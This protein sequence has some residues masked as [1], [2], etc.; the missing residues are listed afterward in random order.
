M[1]L[2]PESPPLPMPLSL[3]AIYDIV[4]VPLLKN[5]F[6]F[7]GLSIALMLLKLSR[8]VKIVRGTISVPSNTVCHVTSSSS[9]PM[10]HEIEHGCFLLGPLRAANALTSRFFSED[11][12]SPLLGNWKFHFEFIRQSPMSRV[13]CPSRFTNERR[14]SAPEHLRTCPAAGRG[15]WWRR[16]R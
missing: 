15:C 9:C 8:F 4:V 1:Y 13:R 7:K 14:C 5:R 10:F 12:C 6:N 3:T 16:R 2:R 11:F